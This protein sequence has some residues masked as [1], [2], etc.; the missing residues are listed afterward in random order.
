[1]SLTRTFIAVPVSNSVRRRAVELAAVLGR[2]IDG[3]KWVAEEN[4]HLTLQFLGDVED[5]TLADVCNCVKRAASD[6][7]PF[8]IHVVGA[9]AYPS[10]RRPRTLWLGVAEGRELMIGLQTGIASALAGLGFRQERRP[11]SPHL[12]LGRVRGDRRAIEPLIGR[13]AD[14]V[15]FDAGS[16]S[17]SEV[18]VFASELFHDGPSYHVLA[19]ATLNKESRAAVSRTPDRDTGPTDGL[20]HRHNRK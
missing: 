13:L 12:T 5:T 11:F 1:M 14:Q 15:E 18:T 6:F 17:V 2:G 4:L 10:A 3:I 9:G 20:P 8:D 7:A 16:M 19:T